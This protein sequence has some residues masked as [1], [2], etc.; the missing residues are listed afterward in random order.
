MRAWITLAA[1]LLLVSMLGIW[2]YLAPPPVQVQTL[3]L[4]RL[5]R[6]DVRRITFERGEPSVDAKPD[7]QRA[8]VVLERIAGRWRMTAPLSARADPFQVDRLLGILEA[9]ATARLPARELA[10]YGLDASSPRVTLD[11]QAFSF[12]GVNQ[13]TRE[14]Y[15]L[16]NDAVYA[17]PLSQR[18]TL[19]AGAEALVSRALFGPDEQPVRFALPDFSMTLRDGRW[20]LEPDARETTGDERTAWADAWRNATA[21]RA[22]TASNRSL[23]SRIDVTLKDGTDIAIG[24]VQWEPELVMRRTDERI[25]YAF[26]SEV[27]KRL[28]EP[29]ARRE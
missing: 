11:Q 13:F 27:A 21:I 16:T 29:P 23:L 4:S 25:E 5:E 24:I 7:A 28:L 15:V 12:G 9:G 1:L 6:E 2:V 22:S 3:A 17:V 10:Q 20:S 19:P 18:A 14:Q 8:A 26:M